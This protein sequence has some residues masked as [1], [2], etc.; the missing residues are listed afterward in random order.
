MTPYERLL[1]E[2]IPTGTFGGPKPDPI[3]ATSPTLA[4]LHAH[5]LD[6]ATAAYDAQHRGQ[7]PPRHL[8]ALPPADAA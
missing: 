1:A 5:E 2:L 3:S 6:C 4:A 7:R 8:T